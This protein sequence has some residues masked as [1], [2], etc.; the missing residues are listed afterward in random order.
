MGGLGN[1]V[2]RVPKQPGICTSMLDLMVR[3]LKSYDW[4]EYMSV[5]VNGEDKA[6]R[7]NVGSKMYW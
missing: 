4:D 3:E 7:I 1:K 6:Y 5:E 2:E